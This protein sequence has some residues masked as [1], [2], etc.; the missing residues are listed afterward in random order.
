MASRNIITHNFGWKL[1]SLLLA[2]LTWLTIETDFRRQERSDAESRQAPVTTT[3]HKTFPIIPITLL[4][5]PSNTNR[6]RLTPE[7][8]VVEIGGDQPDLSKLLAR[9]VQAFVDVSDAQ[10][11]KQFRR[12]IQI[13]IPRDFTVTGIDPT[14]A[15]VER[16]TISH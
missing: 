4:T 12:Q 2:A 10:D 15:G 6:Y 16:I 11:E 5:A 8:V 1:L 13:R 7:T 3:S 14:N 9:D